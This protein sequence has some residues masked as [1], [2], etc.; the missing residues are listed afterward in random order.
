VLPVS[1][2]QPVIHVVAI[3][4]RLRCCV[5]W[6]AH[7][8]GFEPVTFAFGGRH[9]I[10]LSYGCTGLV[11]AHLTAG[12][13]PLKSL[14]AIMRHCGGRRFGDG[15]CKRRTTGRASHLTAPYL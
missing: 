3:D 10:Q 13:K 2:E 5:E 11:I 1:P 4:A 15:R 14:A 7:P 9:S 8:T 6:L 12:R